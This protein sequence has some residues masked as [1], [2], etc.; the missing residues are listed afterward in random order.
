VRQS[1]IRGIAAVMAASVTAGCTGA[2]GNLEAEI[3][4]AIAENRDLENACDF[5]R[6]DDFY[7][8][9]STVY[10]PNYIEPAPLYGANA[11][12]REK[13]LCDAGGRVELDTTVQGV[14]MLNDGA[15][16]AY[17]IGSFAEIEADGERSL[18][19]EFSFVYVYVR[20]G[21]RWKM[22]HSHIAQIVPYY[23]TTPPRTESQP[24]G[25]NE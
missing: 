2:P 22:Q 21:N 1:G 13:E 15:G 20:D 7:T 23:P 5:S 8:T 6:A 18:E 17:G 14:D 3:R 16:I 24:T 25:A 11:E 19:G 4:A 12:G 10:L 9:S